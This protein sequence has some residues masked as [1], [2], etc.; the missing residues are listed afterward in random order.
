MAL[1]S[2]SPASG[3]RTRVEILS[4][5][6]EV[7]TG[8]VADTNAAWMSTRFTDLGF[9]VAR[10]SSVGDRLVDLVAMFR[11]IAARA[12]QHGSASVCI[13][14]GGLGP[15]DD[16]LT[17]QAV[18]TAFER[19]LQLDEVALATIEARYAAYG[20]PMPAVNRRQAMLPHHA[21]RID[22]DHGTAPGFAFEQG[23]CW[24]VCLPGVP[25]EMKA[26]FA[27]QVEPRLRERFGVAEGS[28][29]T[30]RTIGV[31]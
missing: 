10:H 26:M 31:G 11:E 12:A 30:F 13:C 4:Q 19:P 2:P 17:A 14:T 25:R 21:E 18:A 8:Q 9:D 23:P 5:G 27:E 16:D 7:V 24:F 6:D 29:V 20:R 1:A 3:A 22:N 15:T 28:L